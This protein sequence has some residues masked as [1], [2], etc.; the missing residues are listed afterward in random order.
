M[1]NPGTVVA[2][3]DLAKLIG[4]NT[5]HGLVIG[6]LV[7]LDGNLSSHA[8]HGMDTTLVAGLDKEL[9]VS[10][11]E[12]DR[13]GDSRAVRQDKVGVVA[14]LL[15]DAEDIIPATAVQA[16]AVIAQLIDDLV[17]LKGGE[18]GLDKHGSANGAAGHTN[19]VL[20]QVEGV[21]PQTGF[22]MALHLGKV[23]VRAKA[24]ALCL[25]SIVEEVKAKVE[26]RSG[27]GLAVNSDMLLLK[28]PAARADN[29]SWWGAISA[30]LVFLGALLEVHLTT[31]G[32]V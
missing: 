22:E 25:E 5:F 30:Q 15:D 28:V 8:A 26:E 27:D 11:H 3:S 19:V 9:Y 7:I 21:V 17:H 18:N 31:V 23:K 24:A 32:I 1:S 29:Q 12:R 16:G 10:I 14:E 6:R 20:S 2:G 13:H 4:T